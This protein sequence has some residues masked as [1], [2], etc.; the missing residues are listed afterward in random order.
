MKE[1]KSIS[2]EAADYNLFKLSDA[3]KAFNSGSY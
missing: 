1:V 2:A 3:V